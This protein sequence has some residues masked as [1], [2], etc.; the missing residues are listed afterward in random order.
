MNF[1]VVTY[2]FYY[3]LFIVFTPVKSHYENGRSHPCKCGE[4]LYRLLNLNPNENIPEAYEE[5]NEDEDTF[6]D[7]PQVAPQMQEIFGKPSKRLGQL[8]LNKLPIILPSRNHGVTKIPGPQKQFCLF[9]TDKSQVLWCPGGLAKIGKFLKGKP[10]VFGILK[11]LF[12]SFIAAPLNFAL[13][14]PVCT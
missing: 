3:S 2:L 9:I 6:I 13:G 11:V 12:D 10:L 7:G 5:P 14:L 8:I 1:C 4:L